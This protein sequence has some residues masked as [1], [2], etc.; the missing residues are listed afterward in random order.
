MLRLRLW[1]S[2]LFLRCTG[3]SLGCQLIELRGAFEV[4]KA[5][6]ED[7]CGASREGLLRGDS[8]PEHGYHHPM[9]CVQAGGKGDRNPRAQP[10]PS[11]PWALWSEQFC[12]A[13]HICYGYCQTTEAMELVIMDTVS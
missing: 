4:S 10:S 7:T 9:G 12:S 6:S 2:A 3:V 1:P 5:H 11:A 8:H 13:I